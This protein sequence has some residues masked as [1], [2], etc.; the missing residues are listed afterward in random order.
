MNTDHTP[1]KD[2]PHKSDIQ[3]GLVQATF[4]SNDI[5]SG[6]KR[7]ENGELDYLYQRGTIL[8]RDAYVNQVESLV[9]GERREGLI[10]GV[11]VWSIPEPPEPQQGPETPQQPEPGEGKE[12][13]ERPEP[14]EDETEVTRA[15]D[16]IDQR[17]GVGVATPNHVLSIS[18]VAM[19][20]ATEPDEVLAGVGPEP[21][22]CPGHHGSGVFIHV[23]DT[24]LLADAHTHP[25]LAGVTGTTDDFPAPRI[26]PYTGHGTFVAGVARCMAPAAEVH[27]SRVLHHAGAQLEH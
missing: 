17:L 6:I 9:G 7:L 21:G 20:P 22:I 13:Q 2:R 14:D 8:V 5:R 19:C 15:L 27:V 25:W 12:P 1:P 23:I 11:T 16:L 10:P 26:L 24:G 3:A 18:P 4:A